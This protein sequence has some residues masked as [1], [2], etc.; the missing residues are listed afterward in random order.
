MK[1]SFCVVTGASTQNGI[2]NAIAKRF[3]EA[4]GSVFLVAEGTQAQLEL[5]QQECRSYPDAGRIEY[6]VFD[7]SVPG[8]PEAM[9]EAAKATFGR[10]DVL[11]NNAG[12]RAPYD[13]GEYTR[14][15]FDQV[16]AV[17]IGAAFFASQAVLPIMRGQ[18]GGRIIHIASQLGQVTYAKRA[19]Y[20]LTKAAMI[21]L[22]KSMA[23]EL[24]KDN[25][26]VNSI[27]PGP[28]KT[29]PLIDRLRTEPEEMARRIKEYLPAGRLGEPREIADLA[30]FLATTDATFLQ[31]EDIC[32]DGGYTNH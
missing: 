27:S 22:T 32:I 2:G 8:A 17:N 3:A 31:G 29:Q 26:I 13:F 14:A 15:Q 7:L 1:G 18:G 19:L 23:Y 4:G 21:H 30:L 16:I 6:G 5:A 24:A 28:I 11:V 12:I 20:G 9:I 10:I 25:I